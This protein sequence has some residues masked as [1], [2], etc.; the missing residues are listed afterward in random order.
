MNTTEQAP[1]K[2]TDKD[3]VK[4]ITAMQQILMGLRSADT[5]DDR[6]TVMV[7]AVYALLMRK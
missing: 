6:F 1:K 5:E 4:L 7:S 3:V 2:Y